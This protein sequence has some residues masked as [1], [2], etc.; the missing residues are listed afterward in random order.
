MLGRLITALAVLLAIVYIAY[1]GLAV[2]GGTALAPALGQAVTETMTYVRN[3]LTGD[4][5]MSTAATST[6][7]P[8]AVTAV[9][10][11][12]MLRSLGLLGLALALAIMIGVPLGIAAARRRQHIGADLLLLLSIVGV[13]APSFFVA[14]LLQR[15]AI[16]WT[17]FTG[18]SLLP[19]GGFGWDAHIWLPALVLAARPLA[20]ITRMTFISVSEVLAQDYIRTARGKGLQDSVTLVRHVLRNAAPPILTTAGVSLRFALS[21]LPVVELFFGWPGA[22]YM[23]IKGIAAGD[24]PLTVTLLVCFGIV[25]LMLN[26]ALDLGYRLLDPRLRS[27]QSTMVQRTRRAR[28]HMG[29][30]AWLRSMVAGDQWR[31]RAAALR[32]WLRPAAWRTSWA[33]LV[34]PGRARAGHLRT[35]MGMLVMGGLLLTL[36]LGVVVLGPYIAPHSP[37]TTQGMEFVD[38]Q[39]LIPPFAP[40][41]EYPWGTD[42]LGRDIMSLVLAGAR[43]TLTLALLAVVARMALGIVLGT[44]AGWNQGRGID[45]AILGAA[46]VLSAFPT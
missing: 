24:A 1:V 36:L 18:K 8:I 40:D 44:L 2:A 15:A 5:G 23:L 39:F 6:R 35:G 12:L 4:L 38:G 33:A 22:G 9:A 41:A 26:L 28:F 20:Q 43:Q 30:P 32:E 10:G 19:V 27:A 31:A 11:T 21:S 13:S 45:R 34:A 25:F 42:V 46:E 14:L 29:V 37:F 16:H 7:N 3:L 17:Q